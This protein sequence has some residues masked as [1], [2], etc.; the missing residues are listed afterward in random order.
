ML[1]FCNLNSQKYNQDR[2]FSCFLETTNQKIKVVFNSIDLSFLYRGYEGSSL[3]CFF[4]ENEKRYDLDYFCVS[5]KLHKADILWDIVPFKMY[6]Y[7]FIYSSHTY[8]R[9]V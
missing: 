1:V 7:L 6:I 4:L 5:S 3:G 2:V 9:Q 8:M